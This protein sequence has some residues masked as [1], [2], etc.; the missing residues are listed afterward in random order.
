[1]ESVVCFPEFQ[2]RHL[3]TQK[4]LLFAD[5]AA[6]LILSLIASFYFS[7]RKAKLKSA[8]NLDAGFQKNVA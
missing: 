5:A 7:L 1:M 2:E 3:A 6:V 4:L 8:E